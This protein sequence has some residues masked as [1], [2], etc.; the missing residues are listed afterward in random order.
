MLL[1]NISA[2]KIQQLNYER[3]V[4]DNALYQYCKWV[5]ETAKQLNI[6]LL[7]LPSYSLNLNIIEQLWKFT[8]EKILYAKYYE[9][10]TEFHEAIIGFFRTANQKYA[11]D[12][13]QLLTLK[14]QFFKNTIIHPV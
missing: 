8:R 13:S 6:T 2:A 4:L 10:P 7:F 5:I 14:F 9:S 12:L 1:I 3:I 11:T